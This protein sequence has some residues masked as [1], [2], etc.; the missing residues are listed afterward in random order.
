MVGLLQADGE[1]H[2]ETQENRGDEGDPFPG[3]MQV[4]GCDETTNPSTRCHGG[5]TSGVALKNIGDPTSRM[6]FDIVLSDS[7]R[8]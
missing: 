6:Q 4:R 1:N 8:M 7:P 2:L 5:G 3:S